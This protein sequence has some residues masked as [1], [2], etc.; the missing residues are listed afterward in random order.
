MLHIFTLYT[1]DDK[2]QYLKQNNKIHIHYIKLNLPFNFHD[3]LIKMIEIIKNIPDDDIICFI[4]AYDVLI[5]SDENEIISK[6]KEY[7]TQLLLGAELNCY[8]SRYIPYFQKSTYSKY[9]YVNSGG[10]IGYKYAIYNMLLW[11]PIHEIIEICKDGGDQT[12][13]IEYYLNNQNICKLDDK[14][15][16]FQNMCLVDFKDLKFQY[17]RLYNIIMDTYPSIIHFNGGTYL[18]QNEINLMPIFLDKLNDNNTSDLSEYNQRI[19]STCY[20]HPQK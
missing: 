13:V 10:Y 20:P 6:F 3:K 19:T 12:Y 18:T 15:L 2:L 11:K 5:I 9:H 1:H 8:P 17:N 4:D 16:L 7:N 14:C